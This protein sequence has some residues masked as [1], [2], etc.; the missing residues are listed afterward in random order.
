MGTVAWKS[1]DSMTAKGRF[2]V[3][4][5]MAWLLFLTI[6]FLAH[7]VLLSS[8]WAQ[9]LTALRSKDD[10]FR[11]IPFG[12]SSFLIL[13]L[14]FGWLYSRLFKTDG[15]AQKGLAFGAICGGSLALAIFLSWYSFLNLPPLFLFLASL[16]YFV[17]IMGVGFVF[18]YLLHPV[19]VKKRIWIILS[20]IVLGLF[21]GIALQNITP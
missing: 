2:A 13:T 10:L 3:A 4:T 17:E 6:D 15:N 7:A 16:V 21:L 5:L 18:G 14:L 11:L 1:C 9:N 19:S 8:F 12:Y 20:F